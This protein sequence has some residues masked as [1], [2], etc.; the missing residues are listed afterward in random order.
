MPIA[1]AIIMFFDWFSR[2]EGDWNNFEKFWE[3]NISKLNNQK[4]ARVI[5]EMLKDYV[6]SDLKY[7]PGL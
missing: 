7:V 2:A 3:Y 4:G 1:Q 5:V 6:K